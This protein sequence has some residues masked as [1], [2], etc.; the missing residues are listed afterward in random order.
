M[1]TSLRVEEGYEV[2]RDVVL[3]HFGLMK[4]FSAMCSVALLEVVVEER[5]REEWFDFIGTVVVVA[6]V[7]IVSG[8]FV[9]P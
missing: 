6:V 9:I 7:V 4:T 2:V 5:E 1:A 8:V 3:F